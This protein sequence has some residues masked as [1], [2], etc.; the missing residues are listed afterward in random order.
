MNFSAAGLTPELPEILIAGTALLGGLIERAALR[1][2]K[3][4]RDLR[5]A[6]HPPSM[7]PNQLLQNR[8]FARLHFSA[9]A[10]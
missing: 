4:N 9:V 5:C 2:G 8:K 1:A 3:H 7:A 10:M 6:G